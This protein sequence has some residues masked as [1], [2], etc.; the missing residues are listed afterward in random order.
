MLGVLIWDFREEEGNS[1]GNGKANVWKT[2]IWRAM[3]RQ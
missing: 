1:R 3:Y 2:H